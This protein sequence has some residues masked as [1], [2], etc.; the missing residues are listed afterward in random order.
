ML[1]IESISGVREIGRTECKAV[2]G[3][4]GPLIFI[5]LILAV[6]IGAAVIAGT[7]G[8]RV[9]NALDAA[10]SSNNDSEADSEEEYGI[11][12]DE[13]CTGPSPI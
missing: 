1:T 5:A 13:G 6:E 9:K 12:T 8:K 2:E 10:T 11:A 3:G 7:A 4:I